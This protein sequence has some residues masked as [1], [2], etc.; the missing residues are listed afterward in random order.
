M[1]RTRQNLAEDVL[2]DRRHIAIEEP[3]EAQDEQYVLRVYDDKLEELKDDNAAYWN[4]DDN[5]PPLV[6]RA[7]VELISNEVSGA[8]GVPTSPAE[9]R[10][11]EIIIMR[12]LRKIMAKPASGQPIA[13]EYY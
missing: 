11:N 8:Y 13:A 7:L 12:R 9:R 2:R 1:A 6:Y 3:P 4:S 5:I 10:Q